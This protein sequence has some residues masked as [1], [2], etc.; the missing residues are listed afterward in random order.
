MIQ[1]L[2]PA[3]GDL[4]T[5]TP[6]QATTSNL[7]PVTYNVPNSTDELRYPNYLCTATRTAMNET[8]TTAA[9]NQRVAPPVV[10]TPMSRDKQHC[11]CVNLALLCLH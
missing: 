11:I 2:Q 4:H 1:C 9:Y 6:T 8:D 3:N 5:P 10:A 7:I